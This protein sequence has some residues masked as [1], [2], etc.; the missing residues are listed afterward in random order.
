MRRVGCFVLH[1]KVRAPSLCF[2]LGEKKMFLLRFVLGEKVAS[3]HRLHKMF[4]FVLELVLLARSSESQFS[5]CFL[6]LNF[7]CAF[8]WHPRIDCVLIPDVNLRCSFIHAQHKT[9]THSI[10][11]PSPAPFF[12]NPTFQGHSFLSIL[13]PFPPSRVSEHNTDDRNVDNWSM[14]SSSWKLEISAHVY[15]CVST[16]WLNECTNTKG[17]VLVIVWWGVSFFHSCGIKIVTKMQFVEDIA[18]YVWTLC[19]KLVRCFWQLS[20]HPDWT[21]DQVLA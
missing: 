5:S 14:F 20:F 1:L 21:G 4:P 15:R 17:M 10:L 8:P 12:F 3:Q 18:R 2:K 19:S 7:L 16:E 9:H 11:H 6:A 13:P